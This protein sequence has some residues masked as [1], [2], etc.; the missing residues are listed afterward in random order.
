MN[1]KRKEAAI[2]KFSSLV[3]GNSFEDLKTIISE[4]EKA[5]SEAEVSEIL[6][7]LNKDAAIE[8]PPA[9]V[10]T[11]IIPDGKPT[12]Q[13]STRKGVPSAATGENVYLHNSVTGRK[14]L[15]PLKGA[16]RMVNQ[17]PDQYSIVD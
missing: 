15:L 13:Q 17:N 6:H 4:D 7:E 1:A 3:D 9:K 2:K 11:E 8:T 5:Y 16:L 14:N 12:P 10:E